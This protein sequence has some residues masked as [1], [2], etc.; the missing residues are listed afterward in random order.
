MPWK[1]VTVMSLRMEF[2]ALAMT[3]GANIS[4][5]CDRFGISRKTGY[6]W[7]NRYFS[8]GES[9]LGDRARRPKR[10]PNTTAQ[11]MENAILKVRG[12]HPAWGGRKISARLKDLGM[13]NVPAPSTVT[14]ILKRGGLIDE[15]ESA[16]HKAWKRFEAAA[17]NDLWQ[18]DFKGH[19]QASEGRC[20]PLTVLDDHSRYSMGIEACGNERGDTVRE[21]LTWVFRKYGVPGKMLVDNGPPWRGNQYQPYTTLTVWLIR[22][23][24]VV[25][26][27][28]P[29]HPQTLGKEERFHR[30]LKAEVIQYCKGL[31]L[32]QCQSRFDI[33]RNV[34]N[35]ERPHEA[36]DMKVPACRYR[37]NSRSFQEILPPIEYGP[38]DQVR[39][40]WDG[41]WISYKN[42]EYRLPKAFKGQYVALR[43][44]NV[45][46]IMDVFFCNQKIAIINLKEHNVYSPKSVTHVSEH[47]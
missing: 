23:G 6:K 16:K 46:G 2:V 24:I 4:R 37:E 5:L 1:E 38:D 39:K 44:S 25:S 36:L 42:L 21:R 8:E 13:S 3:D 7:I 19:F 9:G 29:R 30:T 26:H 20:H 47:L 22:L 15:E 14:A 17:P 27:S 41:G 45:N 34:Y 18:M 10:S 33:W 43:H 11:A 40:V 28:K 32:T 35:L 12:K 31:E